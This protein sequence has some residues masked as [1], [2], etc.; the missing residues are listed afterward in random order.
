M[1]IPYVSYSSALK[2]ARRASTSTENEFVL[3]IK[4]EV[5]PE[6]HFFPK[7]TTPEFLE[8]SFRLMKK[9]S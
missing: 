7:H 8:K 1:A 4:H 9:F 3:F 6:K 5:I 2:G